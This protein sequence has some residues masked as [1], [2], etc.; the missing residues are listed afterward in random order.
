MTLLDRSLLAIVKSWVE[1][2][3]GCCR[4]KWMRGLQSKTCS[5]CLRFRLDWERSGF[6]KTHRLLRKEKKS[7]S[8]T[9]KSS[10]ENKT[11][12]NARRRRLMSWKRSWFSG[13]SSS[14]QERKNWCCLLLP[15]QEGRRFLVQKRI[16]PLGIK[17]ADLWRKKD[18]LQFKEL[19]LGITLTLIFFL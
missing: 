2:Y 3:F 18:S 12:S 16:T 14:N 4:R 11:N 13:R 7:T 9:K 15:S 6:C 1:W 5:M 19:S 10:I 17:Q 8:E